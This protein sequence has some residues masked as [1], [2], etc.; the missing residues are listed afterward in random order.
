MATASTP[1]FSAAAR[2][3]AALLLI[4]GFTVNAPV[5]S[6]EALDVVV[7]RAYLPLLERYDVPGMAVAVTVD[8]Q[9]HFFEFGVAAKD[10]GTPVTRDTLFEIGSVSKTLTAAL[11]GYAVARG[12]LDLGDHP[13]R[14]VPALAGAPIDD[15]RLHN[16]GTYTAQGLPLQF[17][18]WVTDDEQMIE[19]FRQFRPT[20]AP[21]AVRRYS[22]P[23]IGLLGHA[24]AIALNGDFAQLMEGEL[25]RGLGLPRSYVNVPEVAMGSY[26]WGYDQNGAPVR[27][28]PG[29]FDAQAYGVKSTAAD[30]IRFIERNIDPNRLDPVM[31]QAVRA[32]QVGYYEVGPMV[33]GIG[34]EQYP[35]PVPLDRLLAGNSTEMAMTPQKATPMAP[36]SAGSAR[37][38]NKT[39]STDGFGSYAAFIPD[40]SVG[41]VMLA[42]K[43][44]PIPARVTAAHAVLTALAP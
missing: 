10:A 34:W 20:A 40:R 27:V 33:Q 2:A 43:N 26:A 12:A 29:V 37:L 1:G 44:L 7:E 23:S 39:G 6:A 14:Y 5:A 30:M 17:P 22:N 16:L 42:N 9:Q 8:G 19:Y 4:A 25:M 11:A 15:A 41:V 38:F 24:A 31:R 32:T 35:Y 28:N 21:G 13:S 36:Q 3:L 18:P